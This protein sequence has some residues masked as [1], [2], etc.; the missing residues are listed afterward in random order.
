MNQ[1]KKN[2]WP[3]CPDVG[4]WTFYLPLRLTK[5]SPLKHS[6]FLKCTWEQHR[7]TVTS[8]N[9]TCWFTGKPELSVPDE[10]YMQSRSLA[11][12]SRRLPVLRGFVQK[13]SQASYLS[14]SAHS[15]YS[16]KLPKKSSFVTKWRLCETT[17]CQI[18]VWKPHT[19]C[20]ARWENH[21]AWP[22]S[23]LRPRK[24][25]FSTATLVGTSTQYSYQRAINKQLYCI[26][27]ICY[28]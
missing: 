12:C 9:P 21:Q 20:I 26:Y 1:S 7:N 11:Y 15:L 18:T 3:L 6:C 22:A 16:E 23:P 24:I 10:D 2:T 13:R 14:S 5:H 8:W 17:H 19:W 4:S 28:I 27:Y 25:G